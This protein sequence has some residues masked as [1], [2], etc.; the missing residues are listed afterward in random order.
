MTATLVDST[1]KLYNYILKFKALM[2]SPSF[3]KSKGFWLDT[4]LFLLSTF[5]KMV[6]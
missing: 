3:D 2:K 6:F 5:K 1:P 4:S